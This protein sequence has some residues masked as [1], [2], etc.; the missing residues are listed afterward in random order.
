VK[1]EITIVGVLRSLQKKSFH[2][3]YILPQSPNV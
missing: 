3:D 1:L 2:F